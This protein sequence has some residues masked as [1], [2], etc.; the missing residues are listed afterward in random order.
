MS[1]ILKSNHFAYFIIYSAPLVV[2]ARVVVVALL[3]N[4]ADVVILVVLKSCHKFQLFHGSF[5][6]VISVKGSM[7]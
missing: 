4:R 6:L 1:W 3:L 2:I 5:S 7:K